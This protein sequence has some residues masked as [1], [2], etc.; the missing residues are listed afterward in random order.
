MCRKGKSAETE[1][2]SIGCLGRGVGLTARGHKGS[3]WDD[4][5]ILKLD[6]G[7]GCTLY[8]STRDH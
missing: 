1:S 7:N 2:R 6:C 3:L 8:K 4:G 5:N